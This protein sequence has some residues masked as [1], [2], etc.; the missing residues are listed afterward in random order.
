MTKDDITAVTT[1]PTKRPKLRQIPIWLRLLIVLGL[2][3]VVAIIG[4]MIGYAGLGDGKALD[5]FKAD[6]WRHIFDIMNGK[7]DK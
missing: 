5:V 4:V 7:I 1:E 3:I 2:I 6:V